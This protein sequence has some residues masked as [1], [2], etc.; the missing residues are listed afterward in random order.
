LPQAFKQ[1]VIVAMEEQGISRFTPT[2]CE[3]YEGCF[4]L[5]TIASNDIE[6]V[7]RI[8]SLFLFL[9]FVCVC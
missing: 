7:V 9:I 6:V 1:E 4:P 5:A 8:F 3:E 2:G